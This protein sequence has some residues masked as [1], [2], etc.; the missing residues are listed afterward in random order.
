MKAGIKAAI[1]ATTAAASLV[2]VSPMA[3]AGDYKDG[4]DGRGHSHHDGDDDDDW[5][6][7]GGRDNDGDRTSCDQDN[8]A[9][10]GRG[11]RG[12]GLINISDVNV[13]VPVQACGNDILSGVLG[14]LSSHQRNN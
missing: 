10:H 5:G 3:F 12:G 13:Q 2:A 9:S 6:H 4:H 14:I 7:H 8:S 1:V 11:G